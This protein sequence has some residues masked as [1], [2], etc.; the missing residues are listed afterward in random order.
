MRNKQHDVIVVGAGPIG[1]YTAYLLAKEG[2]DIGLFERNT[3]VGKDV[4]CTGI[5]SAECLQRFD[6]PQEVVSRPISSIQAIAPSGNT[7][8]YVAASP[9]AYV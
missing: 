2:L 8:R 5:V 7:I 4:N 6:L 9:L 1:S 3:A